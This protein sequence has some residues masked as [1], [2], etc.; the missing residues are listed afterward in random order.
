MSYRVLTDAVVR[1]LPDGTFRT[2]VAGDEVTHGK[3][4]PEA[5]LTAA[6]HLGVDPADCVVIEDSPT[7]AAAG[8]A[9]GASVVSVPNAV[10]AAPQ[11]GMVQVDSL[12]GVTA[13][14]LLPLFDVPSPVTRS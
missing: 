14:G 8:L 11:P 3:P 1:Q 9:A 12:A 4:H 10:T 6:A 13:V 7:G 5:Y 2:V